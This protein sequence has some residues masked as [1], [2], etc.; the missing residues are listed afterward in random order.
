MSIK[1]KIKETRM[2]CSLCSVQFEV[3]LNNLRANEERKD[4]I[5]QHFSVYCP[6]CA[7]ANKK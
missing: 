2:Q 3:W 1:E 6:V 7:D 5:L 4:K